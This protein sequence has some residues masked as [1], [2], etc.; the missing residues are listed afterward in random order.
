MLVENL[1]S[2]FESET[3]AWIRYRRFAVEAEVQGWRGIASLFRA[4]AYAEQIH[5]GNHGRILR[6]LGGATEVAPAT[7]EV[8]GTVENLR[9]ALAGEL[10]EVNTT[11]PAY[12]EQARQCGDATVA[13][14]LKWALEAEKTHVRLFEEALALVELKPDSWVWA[15]RAFYVCPVCGYTAEEREAA[16]CRVCNCAWTRFEVVR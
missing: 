7:I 2:A 1:R 5:A 16:M 14:T 9:T 13:R 12:A 6:Q 10:F 4:A 8:R 3:H 15:E 11:Y